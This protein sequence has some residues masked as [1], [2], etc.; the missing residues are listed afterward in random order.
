METISIQMTPE[1]AEEL[2]T[3]LEQ[4][5]EAMRQ[6]NERMDAHE[7]EFEANQRELKEIIARIAAINFHVETNL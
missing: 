3:A 6:S 1:E 5:T 2:R 7:K 4:A